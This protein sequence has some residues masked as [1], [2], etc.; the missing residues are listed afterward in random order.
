MTRV[1]HRRLTGGEILNNKLLFSGN[2]CGGD[3]ALMKGDK[4]VMGGITQLPSTRE[5]PDD[6]SI[7]SQ[8]SYGIND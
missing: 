4:V 7:T 3:K 8:L 6:G 2:F 1:F 5:N